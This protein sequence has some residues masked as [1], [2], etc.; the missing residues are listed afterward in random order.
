[1]TSLSG[2]TGPGRLPRPTTSPASPLPQGA[3]G[4]PDR[5]GAWLVLAAAAL[6]GTTGTAASLAPDGASALAIGA[7]T[8]GLGGLFTLL[9]AGRAAWAVVRRGAPRWLLCGAAA[10]VGYPLAFYTSMSWA[11][12]AV[13]TV[14]S[15]GSA[16]V[17]AA[18]LERCCEGLRL[19]RRWWLATG[20]AGVGCA[21]LVFAG[22][23][24]A[25]GQRPAAGVALGLLA[26][27]GYA[28]YSYCAARLIGDGHGSR[29]TMGALFGLGAVV[30]LPLLALTGGGLLGSARGLAVVGYLAVVPMC[31]AY[32]LFGAGLARVRT[33][34][35][36]T[37]SLLEPLVAALLAVLVV[38]ERLGVLGW[39]GVLLVGA[40]LTALTTRRAAR[41]G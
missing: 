32:L 28:G 10:I 21:A 41:A 27:A 23:G 11:G 6:W 13:G 36:T 16:P 15:I 24:S 12:V 9:L 3:A 7:A 25:G 31:L 35:A 33:S 37:L 14:V 39:L 5:T 4:T 19:S 34:A 22:D 30:L 26:G 17:F 38:G 8:M 20:A 18:L 40:G 2:S 1:M 29:A